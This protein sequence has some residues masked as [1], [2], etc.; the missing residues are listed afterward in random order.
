[1]VIKTT[2]G[3]YLHL[4]LGTCLAGAGCAL[5]IIPGK[6]AGGGVNGISTITYY[7]FHL[8]P[9]LV[10]LAINIPLVLIGMKIFGKMYGL[11]SIIGS[12][13]FSLWISFFGLFNH[14]AGILP[15]TDR[16]DTLLS[17]VFGGVLLGTGI[18]ITMRSGANT[19]GTDII[20]QILHKYTPL[21]MWSC[22]FLPN[23]LVILLGFGVF[24]LQKGLFAI[25]QQYT[26]S[27]LIGFVVMSIGTRTA[28][29][30]Y[31]FSERH[32]DIGRYI[33][34]KLDRGGTLFTGKGIFTKQDRPMLFAIIP[35]QQIYQLVRA[36]HLID[37]KAFVMVSEAYQVMGNGFSPMERIVSAHQLES[38]N[39][40]LSTKTQTP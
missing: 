19:G 33:I 7:L 1:M 37:P 8:D 12:T 24:G 3:D 21:P 4:L 32:R 14:Y 17:A 31:I 29:S 6:L 40:T 39:G 30:I 15:Y 5:F 11:K 35:N 36:I 25:I 10:M 9:G 13:A 20:A 2:I 18:G 23:A 28:K 27:M 22:S 16:M 34:D 26:S 38:G